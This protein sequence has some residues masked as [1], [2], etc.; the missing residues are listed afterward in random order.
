MY[1]RRRSN[2]V[3][4]V[5]L[6]LAAI[7]IGFATMQP[8]AHVS[9]PAFTVGLGD[10]KSPNI[11][12]NMMPN[13]DMGQDYTQP[14]LVGAAVALAVLGLALIATRVRG[15]GVVWRILAVL[16]LALPALAAYVL[17]TYVNDPAGTV[18]ESSDDVGTQLS[19]LG[20]SLAQGIGLVK[21]EPGPGLW[22]LTAG[23]ILAL[24]AIVIPA[25][26]STEFIPPSGRNARAVMPVGY[27]GEEPARSD[28]VH[29][30]SFPPQLYP[31]EQ[32]PPQASP[33]R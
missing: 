3:P 1:R 19:A 29:P 18:S 7:V 13:A 30:Q 24:L 2:V 22:L 4:G 11:G 12:F 6:F 15:L 9:G 27:D 23:T 28:L 32:H 31:P 26:R 16:A 14:F 33:P 5:L 8:W 21:I 20:L 17:W 10:A 25:R